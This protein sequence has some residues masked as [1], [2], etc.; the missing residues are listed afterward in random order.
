VEGRSIATVTGAVDTKDPAV[1]LT[2]TVVWVVIEKVE[3]I[4]GRVIVD[5]AD[6]G[7]IQAAILMETVLTAVPT[8]ETVV[9]SETAIP[10]AIVRFGTIVR[11]VLK[12]KNAV[13]AINGA[14]RGSKSMVALPKKLSMKPPSVLT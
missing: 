10:M 11:N 1:D 7:A 4:G 14:V 2:G 8:A 13:K 5:Q 12:D 9:L 3:S 6:T